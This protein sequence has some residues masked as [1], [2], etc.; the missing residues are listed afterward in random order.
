MKWIAII[1]VVCTMCAWAGTVETPITVK[2]RKAE[3]AAVISG[4]GDTVKVC[5][6]C[7]SGIGGARLV[8]G[9]SP[10]PRQLTLQLNLKG[11]ESLVLDNG[12]IR[13]NTSLKSPAKTPYWKMDKSEQQDGPPDGTLEL[14][15]TQT[16]GSIEI[17]MP[18]EMLAGDPSDLNFTWI[19]FYRD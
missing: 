9:K 5:I 12:L 10:W 15:I 8:R 19:D 17:K 16:D 13:V 18:K 1:T 14:S 7:P 11:L 6:T 3:D 4:T 2:L